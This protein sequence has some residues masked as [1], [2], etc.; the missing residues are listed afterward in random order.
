MDMGVETE[1]TSS[2]GGFERKFTLII[3]AILLII[4][5]NAFAQ[6]DT[7]APKPLSSIPRNERTLS[8]VPDKAYFKSYLTVWGDIAISRDRLNKYVIY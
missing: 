2:P 6:D 5:F 4:Q 3:S 1:K 8:T 7:L